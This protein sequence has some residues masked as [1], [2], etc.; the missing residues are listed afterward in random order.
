MFQCG[1]FLNDQPMSAFKIGGISF[2]AFSGLGKN[3]NR[4]AVACTK[5]SGPIPPGRY[6]IFDRQ[7]GG[8]L[9]PL[10]ELF[11]DRRDWFALYADDGRIDDEMFCKEVRRGNF[12]LHPK[13]PLGR[14][15][16]CIT[17]E[18][19]AHFQHLSAILKSASPIAIPGS[20]LKAYGSVLV[21]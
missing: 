11:N 15:E 3:A 1:F 9:G 8:V 12:R 7:P 5:G 16:G 19:R 6:Y 14:S 10:R 21:K 20:A 18:E 17:I 2:P 4:R 13:G